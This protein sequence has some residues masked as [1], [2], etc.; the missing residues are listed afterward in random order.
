M[1][2]QGLQKA[3]FTYFAALNRYQKYIGFL[4]SIM[5]LW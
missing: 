2:V 1:S 4:I 5:I 3:V